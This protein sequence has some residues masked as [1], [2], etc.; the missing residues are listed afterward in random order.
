MFCDEFCGCLGFCV[1][2]FRIGVVMLELLGLLTCCLKLIV[3][4]CGM[5]EACGWSCLLLV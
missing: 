3:L 4:C 5:F 1:L 2:S